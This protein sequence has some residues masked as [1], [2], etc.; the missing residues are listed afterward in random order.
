MFLTKSEKRKN[1]N[2]ISLISLLKLALKHIYALILA[3]VVFAAI[4]FSYCK[5]VAVPKYSATGS[6]LVTNGSI[7]N[8]TQSSA[9]SSTSSRNI[10]Y[11][12]INASLQLAD[13]IND[14]LNTNDIYKE[15]SNEDGNRYTYSNLKSRSSVKR[16]S[17]DS[18]FIDVTFTASTPEEALRLANKFLNLTP[19]YVKD[20]IPSANTAIATQPDRAGKTYPRTSLYTMTAGLCGVILAYAVVYIISLTNNSIKDED[21]IVN[22]Y[23]IPVLGNVPDFANAKSKEYSTYKKGGYGN[24]EY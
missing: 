7:I 4:A 24:A 20:Y 5:F 2:N 10:S 19:D 1:V 9:T 11:T 16:R 18:L 3:G 14:I 6:V 8:D 21:D 17:T 13:T 15:L 23:D 12:D 22:H